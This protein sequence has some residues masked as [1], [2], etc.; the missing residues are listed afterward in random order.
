MP[1]TLDLPGNGLIAMTRDSLLALRAAMF[2]DL[3]P[4]AAAMLQEAGYA[5]GPALF[6]AFGNWL[7]ARGLPSPES[8]AAGD[9]AARGTEF[10]RDTGWGSIELGALDSV[11]T[12]D[13]TDWAEGD[14]AFPLDFPGCYYTSGVMADFFGRL[15]GEPVAVMEVECRSM[16]GERCRFLVGS[17]ETLQHV[18]EEMAQGVGYADALAG[19][20]R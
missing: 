16:G 2:R 9:F 4:N 17:G 13:S 5:G 1:V 15:A 7:S 6:G 14:P 19:V 20:A 3:G 10:F 11:A 12:V 18:Y 8:L